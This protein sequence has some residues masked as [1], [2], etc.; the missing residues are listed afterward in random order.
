MQCY[1]TASSKHQ[2]LSAHNTWRGSHKPQQSQS[3]QP[4]SFPVCWQSSSGRQLCSQP[5]TTTT[6]QGTE[7]PWQR[8]NRF[9]L[10]DF[11]HFLQPSR[12]TQRVQ[13]INKITSSSDKPAIHLHCRYCSFQESVPWGSLVLTIPGQCSI[14]QQ[15]FLQD[16][17]SWEP[18]A[19]QLNAENAKKNLL[20]KG[21]RYKV[22]KNCNDTCSFTQYSEVQHGSVF[23][24][25][26]RL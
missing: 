8:L 1:Q 14:S 7:L 26:E 9:S 13:T 12:W 6:L 4:H 20:G 3:I 10:S 16:S 24:S 2:S 15:P 23:W 19:L 11:T 25:R 18:F 21:H 17:Y 22:G 5:S